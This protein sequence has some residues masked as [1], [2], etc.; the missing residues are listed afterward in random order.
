MDAGGEKDGEIAYGKEFLLREELLFLRDIYRCFD[1]EMSPVDVP[2]QVFMWFGMWN[3]Q[4]TA[5]EHR[6]FT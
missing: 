5:N 3:S 4:D 6:S 2:W 1:L